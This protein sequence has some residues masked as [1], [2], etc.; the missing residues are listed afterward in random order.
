LLRRDNLS[1]LNASSGLLNST[2]YGYHP[3]SRLLT[4][5]SGNNTATYSYLANS[6][7]LGQIAFANSGAVT[8][9]TTKQYD[10]LNR[11]T[12]IQSG[13]GASPVSSFNYA[14][15][16][17]NQ[18]TQVTNSDNS[19]WIYQNDHLGQ[20]ISGKK[21]W[22]DGT[23][24][25]GL[26]FTYDFDDIGNRKSTAAGGDASG[27]NLRSANYTAN[28]LNQYTSR[29]VPGYATVLGSANPTATVTVNLQRAVRQGG[30]FWDELPENNSV[31]SL[32][33]SL[34]NLAV[35]NNGTNADIVATNVGSAFLPQTPETFGYDADGNMTNDGC[36]TMTWDAENRALSFASLAS[37]P[38]ASQLKVDCTYDFQGRRI[39]KI[40]STNN[41]F[42]WIAVSTNKFVYDGWNLVAI[43]D[44]QSS[45]AQSFTWGTDLSG[46]GQGAGG[47]GGLLTMTINTGANAGTFDYSY[48]GN[49]N[50]AELVDAASGTPAG[51]WEYGPLG[52]II[53]ST[54][55]MA[56]ANPFRF[57]TKYQD[58]ETKLCYYGHRYY[59]PNGGR[60]LGRDPVQE[61][62]GRNLYSFV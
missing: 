48:D 35:L 14:Y 59:D 1:V 52:E 11:L 3:A 50:V 2:A 29:D 60:W 30:Y 37:A 31:S 16:S 43:L 19:H 53:R 40:V 44:S 56:K 41:G 28:N 62:G 23:P 10:Y 18:R 15:N 54:G 25:A 20:V 38:L 7:L 55:S 22:S 45:I 12:A 46:S 13:A 9:T 27:N 33:I 34:T 36:W 57:S 39:E 26:Q 58:D 8:M 51:L 21:Y 5:T 32:Y 24:V 17:A 61:K 47:V 42:G 6:P 49:G 4:V